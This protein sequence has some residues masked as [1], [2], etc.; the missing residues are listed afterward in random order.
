[1]SGVEAESE[2]RRGR[3][4]LWF[5]L[6][7][8]V[9]GLLLGTIY[10]SL[11]LPILVSAFFAYLLLPLVDRLERRRIPRAVAIPMIV[12]GAMA[13]LTIFIVQFSPILYRQVL[14]LVSLIPTAFTTVMET[15]L[16]LAEKYVAGLGFVTAEQVHRYIS[17]V[18]LMS[19]VE[20]HLQAGLVGL[21]AT[22]SRLAGGILNML[23]IPVL[24][25]FFLKDYR[26]FA[27]NVRK[28]IPRDLLGPARD[29]RRRMDVTLRTLI[30]GQVTV[31]GILAVMYVVGLSIV[32][33]R[34]AIV[35]GLVAGI[36]RVIPYM[37]VVV[38]A[39]LSTVVLL[40]DFHG[41][42]QVL[43]VIV[44]FLVVQAIDGAFITPAVLGDRIG[45]HPMLVIASVIA[46][47]NW[48]GFWGV[49][50]AVPIVAVLKV[51]VET[52]TPYYYG[53]AA[54]DPDVT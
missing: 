45:L 46:F 17:G 6:G 19:R 13:V 26:R 52:A 1:M 38:G 41:W 33:L 23:L 2:R 53:S 54:Y 14:S 28:L 4:L 36:C 44:V 8:L 15:W 49:L 43:G 20:A 27:A 51:V 39:V 40:S 25:F 22:G 37:D 21:W 16:P 10:L 34:S 47:A 30:K 11:L 35:I 24:T 5:S 42:G 48:W 7:A 50:L 18:S 12:V 31:A 9:V 3:R 32:G 29:L